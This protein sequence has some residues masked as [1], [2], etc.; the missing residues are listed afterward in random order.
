[1]VAI[2]RH[3]ETGE[4]ILSDLYPSAKAIKN[5]YPGNYACYFCNDSLSPIEPCFR[6]QFFDNDEVKLVHFRTH[7]RHKNGNSD[8]TGSVGQSLEHLCAAVYWQHKLEN[9]SKEHFKSEVTPVYETLLKNVDKTRRPDLGLTYKGNIIACCEVQISK[10][11]YRSCV[12][13]SNDRLSL[14]M[15]GSWWA[16]SAGHELDSYL[17]EYG[18]AYTFQFERSTDAIVVDHPV[19]G[20]GYQMMQESV[21]NTNL[22][23]WRPGE[24]TDTFV[25]DDYYAEFIQSAIKRDNSFPCHNKYVELQPANAQKVVGD[26]NKNLIRLSDYLVKQPDPVGAEIRDEFSRVLGVFVAIHNEN[27]IMV[28]TNDGDKLMSLDVL[29]VDRNFIHCKIGLSAE[30]IIQGKTIQQM[31]T[32]LKEQLIQNSLVNEMDSLPKLPQ[33]HSKQIDRLDILHEIRT[34]Q[35]SVVLQQTEIALE[36]A[37]LIKLAPQP[38][39]IRVGLNVAST[40]PQSASFNWR[41]K[42]VR[43]H[44]TNPDLCYVSYPERIRDLKLKE[45]TITAFRSKLRVL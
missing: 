38:E 6:K 31:R 2:A 8:C 43:M 21:K 27:L 33:L 35:T 30:Q 28:S 44:P 25:P 40:D 13:R 42:V 45:S 24:K 9:A 17:R 5:R 39:A 41:G 1:M 20:A 18:I 3:S 7:F 19:F 14:G 37:T 22:T 16:M 26:K 11:A 15:S 34:E 10:I 12:E 36:E 23:F 4:M 32:E 29:Y